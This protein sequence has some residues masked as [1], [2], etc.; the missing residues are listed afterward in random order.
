MRDG[1]KRANRVISIDL[2]VDASAH[3]DHFADAGKTMSGS[4]PI[5]N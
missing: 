4:F 1:A 2:A 5:P 3:T